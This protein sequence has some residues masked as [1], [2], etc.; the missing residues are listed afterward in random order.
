L[1]N[2]IFHPIPVSPDI[3]D[4]AAKAQFEPKL[5]RQL[6]ETSQCS[7]GLIQMLSQ[8]NNKFKELIMPLLLKVGPMH[9]LLVF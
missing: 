8:T 5:K 6:A 1:L 4:E 2:A 7:L 9:R 3:V